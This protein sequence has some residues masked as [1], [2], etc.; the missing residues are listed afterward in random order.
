ML[1]I[2]YFARLSLLTKFV[3]SSKAF[4]TGELLFEVL[5]SEVSGSN[6]NYH[7]FCSFSSAIA[8]TI[9]YGKHASCESLARIQVSMC[10]RA[11]RQ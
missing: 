5:N 9:A 7:K 1:I 3:F 4:L 2:G 10:S 6:S 11:C 8:V